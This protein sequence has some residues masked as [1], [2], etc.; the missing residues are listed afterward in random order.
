MRS[1]R[2]TP[3]TAPPVDS[4]T[5]DSAPVDSATVDSAA[6]PRRG[7][8]GGL[9]GRISAFV[10]RHPRRIWIVTT[11][12]LAIACLFVPTLKASGTSQTDVFLTDVDSI[13]GQEALSE[14]FPGGSG[15]PVV[16]IA[17]EAAA[18]RGDRGRRC[19]AWHLVAPTAR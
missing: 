5:V 11:I 10:G 8:A 12:A 17:P 16:I 2:T 13:A 3:S 4:A 15:N 9:W 6:D 19:G 1:G 7:G 18:D 14:H